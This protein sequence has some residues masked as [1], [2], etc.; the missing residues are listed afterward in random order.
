MKKLFAIILVLCLILSL[1]ACAGEKT[2]ADAGT[3]KNDAEPGGATAPCE[4]AGSPAGGDPVF[5]PDMPALSADGK[6]GGEFSF[7]EG[8]SPAAPGEAYGGSPME[9]GEAEREGGEPAAAPGADS[10]GG[11]PGGEPLVYDVPPYDPGEA[12]KLTAAEW[13]DNLN[14]PFFT[15]LVNAG[16]I[17]FPSF[18]LDPRC[19]VEVRVQDGAEAPLAD[20]TVTLLDAEGKTLWTARTDKSGAAYLFWAEG[21]TPD[22]VACNGAEAAIQVA[23][24]GD[25]PQGSKTMRPLESVTLTCAAAAPAR[26]GLQVMFIVDTTGSMGDELAYLQ[27]DF[28]A[29]AERVGSEG[30]RYAVSFYRDDGDDYVTRHNDFTSDVAAVQAKINAEFADGGGDTPEAVA[31]VL[32]E[33]L[34]QRTDWDESASKLAFLIF[35]APPHEGKDA[36]L[37]AAARAAAEKGIRVIP[38]VASNADRETELFGRALAILTNGTYVFLTDDSGVGGS[39][40]EPIVGSYDVVLLQDLIVEIIQRYR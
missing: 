27:K 40:L 32:D 38:V 9:A 28:S 26:T 22:R 4:T 7:S 20:E 6:G 15:N 23:V 37:Q 31:E 18:G 5:E 36:M 25:D 30:V 19:R 11:E 13:N 17:R 34:I 3:E 33:C 8:G 35:D 10:E 2:A 14:W 24:S 16:T 29:I 21:E 1:A 39:H 12:L